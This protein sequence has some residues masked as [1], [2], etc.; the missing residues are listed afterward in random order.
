MDNY[1]LL[2]ILWSWSRVALSTINALNLKVILQKFCKMRKDCLLLRYQRRK[3]T[4]F[5]ISSAQSLAS[6][7]EKEV[8]RILF[9][10]L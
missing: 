4:Q 1:L 3:E 9:S 6:A 2:G 7:D 5:K 10:A 8:K